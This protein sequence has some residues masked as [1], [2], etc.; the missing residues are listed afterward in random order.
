MRSLNE[1]ILLNQTLQKNNAFIN[2]SA[3]ENI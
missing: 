3:I 2:L 1:E